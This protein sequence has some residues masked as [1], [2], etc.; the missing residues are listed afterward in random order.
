MKCFLRK[1]DL[2]S[3]CN[4]SDCRLFISSPKYCNCTLKAVEL[5]GEA[6]FSGTGSFSVKEVAE[7]LK[8]S[9]EDVKRT[10]QRALKKINKKLSN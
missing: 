9:T 5:K 8:I 10:E 3:S 4:V 7:I 2:N 1:E 6:S